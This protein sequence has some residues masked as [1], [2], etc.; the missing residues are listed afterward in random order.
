MLRFGVLPL[1]IKT[2]RCNGEAVEDRVCDLCGFNEIETE[3]HFYYISHSLIIRKV[4][5]FI[6][7]SQN[8]TNYNT[9]F[10]DLIY[11]YPDKALISFMN[12]TNI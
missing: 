12:F 3:K 8:I 11:N 6:K 4:T 1:E 9:L 7:L 5:Y 10:T 2:G